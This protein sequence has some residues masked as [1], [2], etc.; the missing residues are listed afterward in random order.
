MAHKRSISPRKILTGDALS[1]ALVGIGFKLAHRGTRNPNLE[2]TLI[3]ASIEGMDRDDLRVLSILVTWLEV[4]HERVNADRLC[5][6]VPL[7]ESPRAQAFWAAVAHWL[8]SDRRL[9]RLAAGR[10]HRIELL[11]TGTRYHLQRRGEDPRFAGSCLLVP[12]GV[13]RDRKVDVLEPR[14]LARR[15]LAYRHRV[16][17]GPTYRA[18]MWAALELDPDLTA[19]E[20]ARRTYGS[21]ATAWHVRQDFDLLAA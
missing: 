16:L 20:L 8:G 11:Q 15:H 12:A 18:D 4:H 6:V 7:L 3:A 19:A 2:D 9:A 13:L 10:P 14:Q 5:R 21:F 17:M 1:R